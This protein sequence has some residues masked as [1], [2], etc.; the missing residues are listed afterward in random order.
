MQV[1]NDEEEHEVMDLL[2]RMKAFEH[3]LQSYVRQHLD[4]RRSGSSSQVQL[5]P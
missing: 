4:F 5:E 1:K 3:G 2:E